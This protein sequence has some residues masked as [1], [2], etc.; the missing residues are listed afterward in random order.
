MAGLGLMNR[1]RAIGSMPTKGE[2]IAEFLIA[3]FSFEGRSNTDSDRAT[4]QDSTGKGLATMR[5][6]MT[7]W[8]QNYGYI[9]DALAGNGNQNSYAYITLTEALPDEF[10]IIIHRD[11]YP[12]DE[13]NNAP[14]LGSNST[15]GS[16]KSALYMELKSSSGMATAYRDVVISADRIESSVAWMTPNS[17]NGYV[18]ADMTTS[19]S[20]TA[21]Q[22]V[23]GK[24]RTGLAVAQ[25]FKIYSIHIFSK[26]FS[27]SEIEKY[28]QK[29]IDSNYTLPA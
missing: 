4:V 11:I 17:Y 27:P 28:I 3:R 21:T 1:R 26:S 25:K 2:D 29:Y 24:L 6:L 13:L 23:I 10:T 20:Y 5:V 16:G 12:E 18:N 15:Q 9:D 14:L 19:T 8:T 7:S 22:L